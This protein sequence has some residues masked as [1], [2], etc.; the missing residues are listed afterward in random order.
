MPAVF[1]DVGANNGSSSIPVAQQNK[2]VTV[3]AFEPTPK[4]AQE[5]IEKTKDLPNYRVVQKA[6]SNEAGTAKFYIAGS[7]GCDWGCSSLNNFS[8]D[9]DKT[10]PGRV[11]FKVT[12]TVDVDVIRLDKFVEE[13]GITR[14]DHLH[15]DVQGKD[16][17][18]LMGLGDKLTT[19]ASGVIEMAMSADVKL[20]KEQKYVL[21]DA[22][23]FLNEN[24][25][26]VARI[27]P[28]DVYCNEVNVY[29][30]R[31]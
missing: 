6:V 22:I 30:F 20:Y 7:D 18:V 19:V 8:E 15:V 25:F 5:L 3:W 1:F 24:G 4:L 9:L 10:W 2:D 23:K 21:V 26:R 31:P 28:N 12:D 17:E 14:I 29:F 27:E 16:L 11:D 13:N